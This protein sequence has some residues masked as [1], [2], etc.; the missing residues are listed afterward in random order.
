MT[1]TTLNVKGVDSAASFSKIKNSVIRLNYPDSGFV[2]FIREA[3]EKI[4]KAVRNE[5]KR[6]EETQ[7]EREKRSGEEG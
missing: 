2:I 7:E 5:S 6:R 4:R 1:S 3:H